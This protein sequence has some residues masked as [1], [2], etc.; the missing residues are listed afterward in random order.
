MTDDI[1]LVS[2]GSGGTI[3]R[4]LDAEQLTVGAN[5]V[6]R[7]RVQIAGSGSSQKAEVINYAP[8]G[9]EYGVVSRLITGSQEL[10][11]IIRNSGST[12]IL[13]NSGSNTNPNFGSPTQPAGS[14]ATINLEGRGNAAAILYGSGSWTIVPQYSM[15][16]L[17]FQSGSIYDIIN[18]AWI[19][20]INSSVFTGSYQWPN[21]A[22]ASQVRLLVTSTGSGAANISGSLVSTTLREAPPQFIGTGS[23]VLP[24]N[25]NITQV[26]GS[27]ISLGS[28]IAAN[29]FPI[30]VASDQLVT[31]GQATMA[32]SVPVTIANNQSNIPINYMV[33]GSGFIQTGSTGV[34]VTV[35]TGFQRI[36]SLVVDPGKTFY[37][38][39]LDI[40][41]DFTTLSA[42]GALIGS[43]SLTGSTRGS[44]ATT[45]ILTQDF[46]NVT[47]ESIDWKSWV[48]NPPMFF[49]GSTGIAVV[50]T[51][52][53]STS[54]RWR[55]NIQGY[56]V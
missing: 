41:A 55:A 42:T 4:A 29:S 33:T 49:T 23:G 50:A 32:N 45:V 31:L 1:I 13:T 18:K 8:S 11:A 38:T 20:Q 30:A 51:P 15:D 5:T 25:I 56:E 16:T 2:T 21:L 10:P 3:G 40:S 39:N 52:A 46:Q 48:F 9:V 37:L 28:L 35:G 27:S 26:S 14:T 6:D 54:T 36:I 34:L 19:N 53:G 12:F 17:T 7:E 24:A 47:T 43:G 44:P 22:G